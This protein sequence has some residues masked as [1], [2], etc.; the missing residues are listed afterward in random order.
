VVRKVALSPPFHID[1]IYKSMAGPIANAQFVLQQEPTEILWVTAYRTE[2]V[3]ADGHS[4]ASAEF[5][6]HNNLLFD[7]AAHGARFGSTKTVHRNRLFTTS[8]GQ[9]AVEL[10]EGF[11]IPLL[12]NETLGLNTQVLNHNLT[13]PDATVRHRITIEYVSD[14]ASGGNLTPLFPTFAYVMALVDGPHGVYG[15][16]QPTE[17]QEGASCLPGEV[18][19]Q[20]VDRKGIILDDLGRQFTGHWVVPPGREERRTL[21]TELLAIPFDTTIHFVAV[22]AHP[23]TESIELRDLTRGEVLFRS[24]TRPPAQGI[25]LAHVDHFSS[26]EGIP[27]YRDHEYEMISV[28]DNTS[29]EDQDAMA[30]FFLYL[31]DKDAER[32]L[33][34]MRPS[35]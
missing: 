32:A 30:T 7:G 21:V 16:D 12:S 34:A 1:K 33:A 3:D 31:R 27:V 18:A 24:E 29:D 19:P 25:G 35:G 15:V 14:S 4:P 28:Y 17:M 23:F 8:Q 26:V 5:M 13:N 10:P 2:V 6:C 22:H 11:G 9:F 20:S